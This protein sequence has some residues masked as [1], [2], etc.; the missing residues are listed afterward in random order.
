MLRHILLHQQKPGP[1]LGA[2][3]MQLVRA[4]FYLSLP[5]MPF[6]AIAAT[7]QLQKWFPWLSF[8]VLAGAVILFFVVVGWWWDYKVM[9]PSEMAYNNA[10]SYKHENPYV[11]DMKDVKARLAS[12]EIALKELAKK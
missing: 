3:K 1:W 6:S 4:L 11:K 5:T 7:P 10:Q 2:L 8:W 12:I 9:L